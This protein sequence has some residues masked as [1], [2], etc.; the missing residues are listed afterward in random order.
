MVIL[1]V[2][3]VSNWRFW[4]S[5]V[6]NKAAAPNELPPCIKAFV[7]TDAVNAYDELRACDALKA[8]DELR[9]YD[10]LRAYDELKAYDELIA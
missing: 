6:P 9:V 1:I 5:L 8:Y 2:P 7:T 4:A 3:L 10:E